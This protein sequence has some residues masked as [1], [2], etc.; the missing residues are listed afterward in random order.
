MA[1]SMSGV[2][3]GAAAVVGAM[4]DFQLY[5]RT[6]GAAELLLIEA[7]L[8]PKEKDPTS[9]LQHIQTM[10]NRLK[11][12]LSCS[13]MERNNIANWYCCKCPLREKRNELLSWDWDSSSQDGIPHTD[14]E[15]LLSTPLDE[16]RHCS[17]KVLLDADC[18]VN[19]IERESPRTTD[20]KLEGEDRS[21][22]SSTTLKSL[23]LCAYCSYK[24]CNGEENPSSSSSGERGT[25]AT[26]FVRQF[27]GPTPNNFTSLEHRSVTRLELL[28]LITGKLVWVIQLSLLCALQYHRRFFWCISNHNTDLQPVLLSVVIE[29]QVLVMTTSLILV[30]AA[31]AA[32][33]VLFLRATSFRRATMLVTCSLTTLLGSMIWTLEGG[34]A[35]GFAIVLLPF[36]FSLGASLGVYWERTRRLGEGG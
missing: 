27:F 26:K 10:R 16:S 19:N 21:K 12:S 9:L 15:S 8:M 36:A 23:N 34:D 28:C 18:D 31:I 20:I 6:K 2:V 14:V 11:A 7:P 32:L 5:T 3:A 1:E 30:T 33:M 13:D 29:N 24:R 25:P 17:V 22:N 35:V 4:F